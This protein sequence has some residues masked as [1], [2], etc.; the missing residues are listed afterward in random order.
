MYYGLLALLA[1]V[2]GAIVW[3]SLLVTVRRDRRMFRQDRRLAAEH[4]RLAAQAGD[5]PPH[6]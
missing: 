3:V 4:H 2:V 5:D 6:S 1:I